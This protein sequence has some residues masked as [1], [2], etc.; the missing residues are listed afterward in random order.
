MWKIAW[1][2]HNSLFFA[3][4]HVEKAC[5]RKQ[6][7]QVIH[8]VHTVPNYVISISLQQSKIGNNLKKLGQKKH[9]H[10]CVQAHPMGSSN[11]QVTAGHPLLQ[12]CAGAADG[13]LNCR[14][15]SQSEKEPAIPFCITL[16]HANM[17]KHPHWCCR[18]L[19]IATESNISR[20]TIRERDNR[21]TNSTI[22]IME[23]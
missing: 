18:P 9:S 19:S 3:H 1:K 5:I 8:F 4:K 11:C 15:S 22:N 14:E 6:L 16:L 23:T 7:Q 21:T 10:S 12:R 13:K 17:V 20:K 2:R